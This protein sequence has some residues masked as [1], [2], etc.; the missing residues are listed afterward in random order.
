MEMMN[1]FSH[2]DNG[3]ILSISRLKRLCRHNSGTVGIVHE[4]RGNKLIV[5]PLI[6]G[7]K[8]FRKKRG[9]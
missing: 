6:L 7:Q 2:D 5:Q 3:N 1:V 8:M 4:D 9:I